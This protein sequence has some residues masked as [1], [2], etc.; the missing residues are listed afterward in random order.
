MK[1]LKIER[2]KS[3]GQ[4]LAVIEAAVLALIAVY[5]WKT[6]DTAERSTGWMNLLYSIP[7]LLSMI[8]PILMAVL[9]S[10]LSELEYQGNTFKWLYP[11]I[12]PKDL[13]YA[14]AG[15]GA[16]HILVLCILESTVSMFIGTV[17]HFEGALPLN[18]F[19]L[20][21]LSNFC[22]SFMI[23]VLQLGLS[24]RRANQI[25]A[26]SIGSAGTFIGI[27]I[28]FLPPVLSYLLPWGYYGVMM[29]V[30]MSYDSAAK[31]MSFTW[32]PYRWTGLLLILAWT[33]LF[34]FLIRLQ[35][36]RTEQ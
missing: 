3:K 17:L 11:R 25:A 9:A 12:N 21:T 31:L 33:A 19:A 8:H 10:R 2:Q 24:I 27:F 15:Y 28:L 6:M 18:I 7:I 22:I 4:Y 36:S 20:F 30:A 32:L 23:Y 5:E 26:L 1:L 16:L 13:I 29:P 14:K 35:I 34:A